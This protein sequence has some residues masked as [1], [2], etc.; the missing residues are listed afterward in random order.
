MTAN[1]NKN[2]FEPEPEPEVKAPTLDEWL[3]WA[4]EHSYDTEWVYNLTAEQ[5][6]WLA[7]QAQFDE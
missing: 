3:A 4:D 6:V 1:H 5:R 7:E 2:R